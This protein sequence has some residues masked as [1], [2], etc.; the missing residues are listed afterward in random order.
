MPA[1]RLQLHAAG[2]ETTV[3]LLSYA[4]QF[5]GDRP[6][7]QKRLREDRSL[8][9]N[10]VEECMR[11]EGPVKGDFRLT[12]MPTTVAVSTFRPALSCLSPTAR[13]TGSSAPPSRW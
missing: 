13:R 11:T 9:P 8:I 2:Q 1:R 7:I 12:K 4:F 5:I 6:D 3:R 10:F